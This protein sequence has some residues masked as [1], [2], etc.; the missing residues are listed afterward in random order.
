MEHHVT[1]DIMHSKGHSTT[2]VV[3]LPKVHNMNIIMGKYQTS[4]IEAHSTKELNKIGL[5]LTKEINDLYSEID[6]SVMK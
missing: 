2:S 1:P 3:F 4:P 6:K 5:N